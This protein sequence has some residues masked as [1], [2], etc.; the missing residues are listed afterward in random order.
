MIAS[1]TDGDVAAIT[2][3]PSLLWMIRS[4]TIE[5]DVNNREA[6]LL[7]QLTLAMRSWECRGCGA[8]LDRDRNAAANLEQAGSSPVSGRGRHVRRP[9]FGPGAEAVEASTQQMIA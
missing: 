1:L 3:Q 5:L 8:A 2:D 4:H 7:A 9:A 6:S